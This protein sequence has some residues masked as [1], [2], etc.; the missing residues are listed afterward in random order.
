V[1]NTKLSKE[2]FVK[3]LSKFLRQSIN[4]GRGR[5]G[6]LTCYLDMFMV[7]ATAPAQT[8]TFQATSQKDKLLQV[9]ATK[10]A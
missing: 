2:C 10:H 7:F 1:F 6:P 4:I 3:S 9:N 5:L 8:F